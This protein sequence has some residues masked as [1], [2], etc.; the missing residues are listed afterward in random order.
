[1]SLL[2]EV[3]LLKELEAKSTCAP[4]RLRH[5]TIDDWQITANSPDFYIGFVDSDKNDPEMI[6]EI[7]NAAP[8]LLEVLGG[9]QPGDSEKLQFAIRWLETTNIHPSVFE[10]LNRMQAMATKMEADQ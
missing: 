3:A 9:F 8:T 6:T 7:R 1:M 2:S 10:M 5:G 4:W